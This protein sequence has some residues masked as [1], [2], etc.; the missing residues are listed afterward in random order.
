MRKLKHRKS[1]VA[2]KQYVLI[3]LVVFS[4]LVFAS[5]N[6]KEEEGVRVQFTNK[7]GEY[8]KALEIND[9]QIGSLADEK[10]TKYIVFKEFGFDSGLPDAQCV[11]VVE[12][13][14]IESFNQF[15]WCGTEKVVKNEGKYEMNIKLITREDKTYFQLT[16][17]E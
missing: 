13:R 14:N 8:I 2:M 10:T 15:Y 5:C 9:V 16:L 11:G 4:S 6:D 7:T 17:R 1:N 12:G 3:F